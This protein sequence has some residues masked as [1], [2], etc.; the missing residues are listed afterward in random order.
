MN[1]GLDND[2]CNAEDY[3]AVV[4]TSA[5]DRTFIQFI[6]LLSV[7]TFY[8]LSVPSKIK[9]LVRKESFFVVTEIHLYL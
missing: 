4:Q 2:R 1:F 3:Q 7:L 5:D 6:V 8:P 9:Q